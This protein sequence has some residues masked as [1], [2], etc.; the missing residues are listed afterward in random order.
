ML[1]D[2]PTIP[3]EV[4]GNKGV[5]VPKDSPAIATALKV[6][7][8]VLLLVAVALAGLFAVGYMQQREQAAQDQTQQ[9]LQQ[10]ANEDLQRQLEDMQAKQDEQER[11][12]LQQQLEE[13]QQSAEDAQQKAEEAQQQ[14]QEQAQVQQPQVVVETGDAPEGVVVTSPDYTYSGSEAGD[15]LD[16]A[17]A[18]Y[19]AAETGDYY[20]TYNHLSAPDQGYYTY[21]QW[22]YANNALDSA[23][24]EFVIYDVT[25]ESSPDFYYVSLTVYLADGTSYDR[26]TEFTYEP[27]RG[28]VHWL[29]SE[30]YDMFDSVL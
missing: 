14:A 10:Q 23:A 24:G 6:M 20:Y 28:W 9:A 22:V 17:I 12:E 7:I 11:A 25:P 21:D 3:T 2:R 18:Y 1:K 16:A 27:G 4:N 29:T 30:E 15:V 8:G 5:I 26:T 13:A 19:Q